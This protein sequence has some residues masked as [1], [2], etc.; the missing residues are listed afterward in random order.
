MSQLL[1]TYQCID[2]R[3]APLVFAIRQWA[4]SAGISQS[5]AGQY[6]SNFHLIVMVIFYLQSC[7]ILPSIEQLKKLAGTSENNFKLYLIYLIYI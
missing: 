7:N 6:L 2:E 5:G 1:W 4:K 3:V